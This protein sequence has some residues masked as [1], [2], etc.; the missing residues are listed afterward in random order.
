LRQRAL[1]AANLLAG[2]LQGKRQRW[3]SLSDISLAGSEISSQKVKN[4]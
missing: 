4:M 3:P 1:H 2:Y